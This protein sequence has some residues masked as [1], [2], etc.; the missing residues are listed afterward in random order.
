MPPV[1]EDQ[2]PSSQGRPG[3]SSNFLFIGCTWWMLY[4]VLQNCS[5]QLVLLCS[6]S[7]SDFAGEQMFYWLEASLGS[8]H[9][10]FRQPRG[11][12]TC[13]LFHGALVTHHLFF[14]CTSQKVF[15]PFFCYL[16]F[17]LYLANFYHVWSHRRFTF[18]EL[19]QLSIH[20]CNPIT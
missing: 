5:L 15:I 3:T 12:L 4:L 8:A 16:I 10:H 2:S 18:V 17:T 14:L 11:P 1:N 13:Q 19:N 20:L 7:L 9:P 6:V